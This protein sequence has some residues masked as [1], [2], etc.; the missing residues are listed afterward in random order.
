MVG[1]V[2]TPLDRRLSVPDLTMLTQTAWNQ[3]PDGWHV[4]VDVLPLM[5]WTAQPDGSLEYC[6]QTWQRYTG[7]TCQQAQSQGWRMVVH[8]EDFPHFANCWNQALHTQEGYEMECRL[9]QAGDAQ[10]HRHRCQTFPLRNEQGEILL[11][12]GTCTDMETPQSAQDKTAQNLH[13]IQQVT[14]TTTRPDYPTAFTDSEL[15]EALG[16]LLHAQD[17]KTIAVE[18][19]EL[20]AVSHHIEHELAQ[21]YDTTIEGWSRILDL[22]DKEAE[23]HSQRVTDMTLTLARSMG[24]SASELVYIRWGALLHDIGKMGIS[25]SILLKPGLLTDVEWEI[26]RNH[27][28]YAYQMLWPVAFLRPAMDIP[29]CHHEKWDGSGYPNGLKGEQIPLA[30]RLFAVVDV[31]DALGSDRPYRAGWPEDKIR[32][33]ILA[34]AGSHFDPRVVAMFLKTFDMSERG[35]SRPTR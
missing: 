9:L 2:H 5:V 15:V 35:Q 31:W 33:H 11:W 6:N 17:T 14:D 4:L 1:D 10:Y 22:R 23:G 26:M 8:P 30:A 21:A 18:D 20:E 7:L 32:E 3:V 19:G 28:E 29:Y 25:D 34:E 12:V 16:S 24:M 27:P 13:L